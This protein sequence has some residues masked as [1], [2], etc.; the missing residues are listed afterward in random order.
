MKD[1]IEKTKA[2]LTKNKGYDFDSDWWTDELITMVDEVIEAS[3]IVSSN[4]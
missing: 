2:E 3:M 4:E 1:F